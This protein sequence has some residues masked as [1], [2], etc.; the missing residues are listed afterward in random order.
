MP[1]FRALLTGYYNIPRLQKALKRSHIKAF[2]H[3]IR[4]E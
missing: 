1:V 3:F 4:R 2:S